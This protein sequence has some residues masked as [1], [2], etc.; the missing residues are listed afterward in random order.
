MHSTHLLVKI[1]NISKTNMS[2]KIVTRD[3]QSQMLRT[4]D[5]KDNLYIFIKNKFAEYSDCF[6]IIWNKRATQAGFGS[7]QKD[8]LT[9]IYTLDDWKPRSGSSP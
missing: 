1:H 9:T 3:Q 6:F 4:T 7:L 2:E 8:V 5:I